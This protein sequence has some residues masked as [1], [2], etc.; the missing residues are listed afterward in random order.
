MLR[1]NCSTTLRVTKTHLKLPWDPTQKG[2]F[3]IRLVS[4]SNFKVE[5]RKDKY[6]KIYN[7]SI[8]HENIIAYMDK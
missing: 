2:I 5:L 4:F 6:I 3:G 7:K 1:E 8:K